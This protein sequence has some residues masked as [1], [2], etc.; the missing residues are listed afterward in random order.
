VLV[1]L[2]L[3]VLVVLLVLG[4]VELVVD[5]GLG[6]VVLVDVRQSLAASSPTVLAPCERL[7]RNVGLTDGGRSATKL[8][9]VLTAFAAGTHWPALTAEETAA[10]W[11]LRLE[12]S[13]A[14]SRPE[15]PPQ[16]ARKDVANPS[17]PAIKARG[18]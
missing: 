11:L 9:N 7:L 17:P 6:A 1:L 10:S 18:A 16:A 4:V 8:L 12:D 15:P 14:V 2:V 13:A 3:L 5:F